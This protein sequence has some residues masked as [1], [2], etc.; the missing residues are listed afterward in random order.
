MKSSVP[1]SGHINKP[2]HAAE[3]A[4]ERLVLLSSLLPGPMVCIV[5]KGRGE[6]PEGYDAP[7]KGETRRHAKRDVLEGR[8][9][10]KELQVQGAGEGDPAGHWPSK[11]EVL[12][13]K[14][15]ERM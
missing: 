3:P 15:P 2:P 4:A 14:S 10:C 5:A 9:V 1:D 7:S 8:G 11:H 13:S 12:V 6:S